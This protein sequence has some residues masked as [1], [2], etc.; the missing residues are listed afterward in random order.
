MAIP[1]TNAMRFPLYTVSNSL[2]SYK[3]PV[4]SAVSF[5]ASEYVFWTRFTTSSILFFEKILTFNL[6]LF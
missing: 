1:I 3:R 5:R 2:R 6:V 4:I